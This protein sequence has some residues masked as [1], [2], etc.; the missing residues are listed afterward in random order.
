MQ[1][2]I[3]QHF[4]QK[5]PQKEL[6]DFLFKKPVES[7]PTIWEQMEVNVSDKLIVM[8]SD[9]DISTLIMLYPLHKQMN[10]ANQNTFK[11][12]TKMIECE[13]NGHLVEYLRH[14]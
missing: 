3:F 11:F 14:K 2:D 7:R 6:D 9:D 1:K 4:P 12:I 8:K 10:I 13:L 5:R